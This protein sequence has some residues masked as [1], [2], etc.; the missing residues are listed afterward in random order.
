MTTPTDVA[1]LVRRTRPDGQVE[2][3]PGLL[4]VR[5]PLDNADLRA[6]WLALRDAPPAFL[7]RVSVTDADVLDADLQLGEEPAPGAV[8]RIT[9]ETAA[10][11]GALRLFFGRSLSGQTSALAQ[12]DNVMIADMAPDQTFSTYRSR[13]QLWTGDP[14]EAFAPSEPL[15]DPRTFVTD[16]T[17]EGQ[18]PD[19]VRPWL[20]RAAPQAEGGA[21]VAWRALAA[22]RLLAALAD[23]VARDHQGL[24]AYHFNGPLACVVTL[25]DLQASDLF[26][27]LQAGAAWVYAESRDAAT[28]HLLLAAEW[29]RTHRR[30]SLEELGDGSLASAEAAWAAHVKSG[31]RETLKALAE[32][33]KAVIDE[34]QKIAQRAQDLAGAMWKDLA[35]A[36][37]PFVLKILPDAAK[38]PNRTVA[39][40]MALAAAAFL[41]FSFGVQIYIN[42][43]YFR[44]QKA[45]RA[46]WKRALNVA[47]T[48]KEVAEF[49]DTPIAESLN[50]YRRVRLAIAVVYVGLVAALLWFAVTNF[51]TPAAPAAAPEV[52][53]SGAPPGV[54]AKASANGSGPKGA[55]PSDPKAAPKT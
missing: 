41:I 53:A 39:G 12:V 22:R 28:R 23:R 35:V 52:A 38:A 42:K 6:G 20:L 26:A 10:A 47:L 13:F 40:A 36:A 19:D 2:E 9:V 8:F 32:L 51:C 17:R 54:S 49:S 4:V 5:A 37:A 3:Q 31:S 44:H 1:A 21:Y 14:P 18:T 7:S 15:P 34:S 29:A 16:F 45:A 25:S 48:P 27:R 33:R 24:L 55:Q 11:P 46:V 30:G 43:R 50:D